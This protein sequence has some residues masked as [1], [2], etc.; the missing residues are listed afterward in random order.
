MME[1]PTAPRP[2]SALE[3][4]CLCIELI[5]RHL[6]TDTVGFQ[7]FLYQELTSTNAVLRRLAE[8]GVRE[9]TVVLAETQTA[10]RGRLGKSWFSPPGVN[11]Y[12]SVLFRPPIPRTAV[13]VF[14][15]ITSLALS[16][17]IGAEGVAA[18]IR[19]PNDVLIE[20]K[21]VAG[22]LVSYAT[23]G[24]LAEYVI[25]GA[26]VNLNVDEATL[27]AALG[28]AGLAATSLRAAAGRPIDRNVF[29]AAFLNFLEKWWDAY[30]VSGPPAVLRAWREREILAGCSLGIPSG[31]GPSPAR[32]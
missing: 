12:V 2:P 19:W 6:A 25:L 14:S 13:P 18:A 29:A 11:L 27:A 10:G 7:I 1:S 21:K 16:D 3:Q 9:G 5:R 23:A 8:A 22:T 28:P 17:A 20:G 30:R 24:D 31:A 4:D 15:F 26:G 32:S